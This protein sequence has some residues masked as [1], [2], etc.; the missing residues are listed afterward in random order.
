MARYEE[1]QVER[2]LRERMTVVGSERVTA[3]CPVTPA[4]W[5]DFVWMT[6]LNQDLS[7]GEKDALASSPR[8][9]VTI[10]LQV[11]AVRPAR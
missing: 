6:P 4:L 10:D 1:G 7:A 11:N 5:R 8:E 3:V 2:Y 9:T